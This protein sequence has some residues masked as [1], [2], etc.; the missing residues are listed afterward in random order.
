VAGDDGRGVREA[1]DARH[2]KR[3]HEGAMEVITA[4]LNLPPISRHQDKTFFE[5]HAACSNCAR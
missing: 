4:Y 2:R 5:P 1:L 3:M